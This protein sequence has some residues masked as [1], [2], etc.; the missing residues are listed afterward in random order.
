MLMN[1]KVAALMFFVIMFLGTLSMTL[2][3]Q[4][5][6]AE[7]APPT[8]FILFPEQL[9]H[10][11]ENDVSLT[12]TVNVPTDWIGYS[13]NDEANVTIS[14]NSTLSS[15]ADGDYFVKVYA[16]DTAGNMG[17]SNTTIFTV[18]TTPPDIMN[19]YQIPF[20]NHV[21]PADTVHITATVIDNTSFVK[22]ATLNY[23]SDNET[24]STV[25]MT[26]LQNNFFNATIPPFPLGTNVTYIIIAE[27]NA[28]NIITT[29]DLGYTQQYQVVP[30]FS[31]LIVL[32]LFMTGT[33]L[34]II[35][36]ARAKK[37]KAERTV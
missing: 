2:N 30:E 11:P 26:D 9:K 21:L 18:D 35:V 8:I 32:S 28:G 19:V 1:R 5:A 24:W 16:N 3:I 33:L 27:D 23:T 7:A 34:A 31:T 29:E 37:M 12:F 20:P 4:S 6:H 36:Y 22:Q 14:G 25:T 17:A 10:Y 15:L 13:L